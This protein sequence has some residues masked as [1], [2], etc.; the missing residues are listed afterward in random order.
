VGGSGGIRKDCYLPCLH[1]HVFARHFRRLLL[2]RRDYSDQRKVLS[3]V[4]FGL[5]GVAFGYLW[6]LQFPIIKNIWSS[7][8]VL[9]TPATARCSWLRSIG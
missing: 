1:R 6:G 7:S 2:Q 5:A 3:L 9:L 4:G 8:Y